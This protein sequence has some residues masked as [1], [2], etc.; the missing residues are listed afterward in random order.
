MQEQSITRENYRKTT[1]KDVYDII[2]RHKQKVYIF[3]FTVMAVV[4]LGNIF[5]PR[6]Y[7]S[8]AT[9]LI[10]LGRESLSLD[11][12]AATGQIISIQQKRESIVNS[13]LEILTSHE[14]AGKVVD[15][16]GADAVLKGHGKAPEKPDK[17]V[18]KAAQDDKT[19]EQKKLC[20]KAARYLLKNL[21]VEVIKNTNIV[22]I[23]Y[24][25]KSPRMARDILSEIIDVYL[26][27][28][29]SVYRTPGSYDFFNEQRNG[30]HKNL[31]ETERSIRDIKNKYNI[32][33][34]EEQRAILQGRIGQLQ[35]QTETSEFEHAIAEAKVNALKNII[36]DLP[37]TVVLEEVTGSSMSASDEMR[38]RYNALKMRE[39]E[40][41]STFKE[42]SIAV[43][44]TR[45]QIK[46]AKELLE[47]TE[48]NLQ[49]KRGINDNRKKLEM[50]LAAEETALASS[51]A[52]LK[53]L[54]DQLSKAR[55]ELNNINNIEVKLEDL[56]RNREILDANYRHYSESLEQTRIDNELET[57]KISN[58]SI[59]QEP[60]YP[61]KAV[62]PRV[63]INIILGL[64]LGIF[65]GLGL[66]F[67]CDYLEHT[68]RKPD[69]IEENLNLPALG[70][71]PALFMQG[72]SPK[73][74]QVGMPVKFSSSSRIRKHCETVLERLIASIKQRGRS[75]RILSVTSCHKTEGV[76]TL[77]S[78]FAAGLAERG[79]GRVL[80]VDT[81]F[82]DPAVPEIFGINNEPGL[83]D[84]LIKGSSQASIIQ[85]SSVNNLDLLCAGKI[86]SPSNTKFFESKTFSDLLNH[87]RNEYSF[88]VMDTPAVWEEGHAV[89]LAGVVDIAVLVI[90]AEKVRW[91]VAR[92]AKERLLQ[93]GV[94]IIG[95]VLNKRRF[96]VPAWLYKTLS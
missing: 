46:A 25:A 73:K 75:D 77:S 10:K 85:P 2:F 76:S 80:L 34:L 60:T 51:Q 89:S 95:V 7:Q 59:T 39:K 27:K 57:D 72:A 4:I 78:Y 13:E 86:G 56:M 28:H 84:I 45:F 64:F 3:F 71:V 48:E 53:V 91:E 36:A 38:K 18:T 87:W 54:C 74:L 67:F 30:L 94:D 50:Q 47:Q 41:L 1:L 62:R 21:Q 65:G 37:D 31:L 32:G 26:A 12:T 61:I 15:V 35:R 43:I 33:S 55:E 92:K 5:F 88:V 70:T 93:S 52:K 58:I 96:Y 83:A 68:F 20:D 9:L 44:E 16:F 17:S 82:Q 49:V 11:P 66:A 63:V 29:I 81:N 6:I 69:D 23:S 22:S 8:N 40:L 24:D 42:G 14:L 19:L 90:E 79:L